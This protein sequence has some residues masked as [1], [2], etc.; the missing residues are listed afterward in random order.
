MASPAGKGARCWL[1][2]LDVAFHNEK[3]CSYVPNQATGSINK[4]VTRSFVFVS[5]ITDVWN[6]EY[7]YVSGNGGRDHSW[8][9]Q[10][11]KGWDSKLVGDVVHNP[12]SLLVSA[13]WLWWPL[14][15][16]PLPVVRYNMGTWGLPINVVVVLLYMYCYTIFDVPCRTACHS[17]WSLDSS[18]VCRCIHI[19]AIFTCEPIHSWSV[20]LFRNISS[21]LEPVIVSECLKTWFEGGAHAFANLHPTVGFRVDRVSWAHLRGFLGSDH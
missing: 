2:I 16:S 21:W 1:I 5:R 3:D 13:F 20:S 19:I 8:R 17:S 6:W 10:V 9:L 11:V 12:S 14:W 4:L 15:C 18:W 7:I